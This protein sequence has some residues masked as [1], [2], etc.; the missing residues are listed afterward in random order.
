MAMPLY[1]CETMNRAFILFA[2]A[3]CAAAVALGALGAHFLKQKAEAGILTQD[4]INAFETAVR[5]QIYHSFTLLIIYLLRE[6]N[7]TPILKL[8]GILFIAGIFLF[9]GSI[10]F[11]S[12]Q[13]LTGFINLRWLGPITPLGGLCFI[14]G[15]LMLFTNFIKNKK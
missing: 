13:N 1:I 11:L 15:W 14:A 7:D 10:Y 5:Y 3:S 9:S 8:S 2:T 12:T 6:K 4:N